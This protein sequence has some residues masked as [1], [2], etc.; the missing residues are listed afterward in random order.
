MVCICFYHL[1]VKFSNIKLIFN[2]GGTSLNGILANKYERVCGHKGYSYDA[3]AANERAKQTLLDK[4]RV[5]LGNPGTRDRVK[6]GTMDEIGYEDCD[7]ISHEANWQFWNETF[8]AGKFHG[9]ERSQIE[10]HVPC[11][12]SIDHVL[13]VCNHFKRPMDCGMMQADSKYLQGYVGRCTFGITRFDKRLLES[14]NVKCYDF[15]KQFNVYTNYMSQFLSTRRIESTPYVQR[16]S[17][18]PRNKSGECIWSHPELMAKAKKVLLKN[19]YYSFCQSCMGTENEI[20]RERSDQPYSLLS[21]KEKT[22]LNNTTSSTRVYGHIQ[23]AK[24][25]GALLNGILANKFQKV[26]GENGYSYDAFADDERAKKKKEL[27][28]GVG[29]AS[30]FLPIMRNHVPN[31]VLTEIGYEYCDF[32]SH[33]LSWTFWDDM[34]RDEKFHGL[35]LELH[36]PC[37]DRID[38]LLAQCNKLYL[39]CDATSDEAFY[40]SIDLCLAGGVDNVHETFNKNLLKQFSV[41]CFDYKKQFS[42]YTNYISKILSRRRFWS[43]PYIDRDPETPSNKTSECIWDYP[44]LMAKAE[45]YLLRYDYYAFCNSCIG[46]ENEIGH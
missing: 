25:N 31:R 2:A 5:K 9:L 17:N 18:D 14:F 10:L 7:Y 45:K 8:A 42:E 28:E 21:G 37:R 41:R 6:F 33:S 35:K 22:I 23:V 39:S 30:D 43:V 15:K 24:T 3:Y 29:N 26:C 19:D 1:S 12:E 36:V 34:F 44:D 16:E 4:G 32:I 11:R 20:T 27:S 46:T 38:H 40:K 13:S